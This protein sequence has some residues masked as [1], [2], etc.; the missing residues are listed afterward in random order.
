MDNSSPDFESLRQT[1]PYG[2]EYWSARDLGPLLGYSKWEN[3]QIAI[4]RAKMAC[5][6]IGQDIAD[7]FPDVRKMIETGK[8]AKRQVKD[9]SLSR[10]ACYL[11]AQNGDPRKLEI[12][13]AQAYFAVST[14]E[15]EVR[16][17]RESQEQRLFLR[18]RVAE[19][20][21]ELAATAEAAGVDSASFGRFENSGYAG[22][23]GGMEP[24]AIKTHKGI[25]TAEDLLD[26]IGN[27]ELAA[28]FFRITQAEQKLRVEGIKGE[29]H[30]VTAHQ[31]VGQQVRAAI[32]EI[33][34]VMPED[35]AAE[36]S[37]KPLLEQKLRGKKLKEGE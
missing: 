30:A 8:G 24:E 3:F 26:R 21:R 16:Q 10:F 7:H 33:S 20:N 13:A 6:Q 28:N 27:T 34:G 25:A 14:R 37:I 4:N 17:I 22:L 15:N 23:Y 9:F 32:S 19:S 35:L 1:N 12:A 31:Q 18:E 36:P 5:E 11:I 2:M 29:E